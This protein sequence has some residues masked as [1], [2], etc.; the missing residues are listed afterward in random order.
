MDPGYLAIPTKVKG[1]VPV[2]IAF[3]VIAAART[4]Y[5]VQLRTQ[6]RMFLHC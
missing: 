1:K 6:P 4:I 5:S 3:T 2:V